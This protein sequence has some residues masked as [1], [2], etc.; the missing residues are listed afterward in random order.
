MQDTATGAGSSQR[1]QEL[2]T[3]RA[4]GV[5]GKTIAKPFGGQNC[6]NGSDAIVGRCDEN[7][8]DLGRKRGHGNGANAGADEGRSVRGAV[9][10]PSGHDGDRKSTV[11]HGAAEGPRHA[12]RP[13][14]TDRGAIHDTPFYRAPLRA[15]AR[16]PA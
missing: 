7:A 15:V 4:A 13:G 3:V 2:M 8:R 11:S 5:E 14:D 1:R 10:V 12:T 9:R 6:G 16:R